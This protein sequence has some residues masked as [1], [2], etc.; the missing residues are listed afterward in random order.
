VETL[1]LAK[2]LLSSDCFIGAYF[3]A[4]AQQRICVA[5]YRPVTALMNDVLEM[6]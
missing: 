4:V 6:Y 3:T 5:K 1:L 2:P